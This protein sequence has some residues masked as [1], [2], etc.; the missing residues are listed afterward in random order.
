MNKYFIE[1]IL[2]TYQDYVKI[3]NSHK[4]GKSNDLKTALNVAT[5][6]YHLHEHLPE[7]QRKDYLEYLALC[8]DYELLRDVVNLSKHK[9]ITRYTPQI[10]NLDNIYELVINT[11]YKDKRGEY[12]DTNK[13]VYM[14]LDDRSERDLFD[15][16]TNVLNMW[17]SEFEQLG[18]IK[19][20]KPYSI[21]NNIIPKR[22]RSSNRLDIVM[23]QGLPF[24]HRTKVQK[25]N[26]V[27]G[28]IEPID[29]TNGRA[30]FRIFKP[31]YTVK[32]E[33]KNDKTC[34]KKV[35]QIN[36]DAEQLNKLKK[37][38]TSE[39]KVLYLIQLA[40]EQGIISDLP[41]KD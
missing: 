13:S 41:T 11:L 24:K 26:Y 40:K 27:K 14:T 30:E 7:E 6:L 18:I 9:I 32:L 25:F 2:V 16:I 31:N 8:P 23:L 34:D 21:S 4:I 1:N 19:H 37:L 22:S 5:V 10:S 39:K 38:R 33:L 12:W 36:I 20:I 35:Y 28:L 3:R 29:L 15:V 17:I